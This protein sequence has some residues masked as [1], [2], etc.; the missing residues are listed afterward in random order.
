MTVQEQD[1]AWMENEKTAPNLRGN[2]CCFCYA[3]GQIW[4]MLSAVALMPLASLIPG[5]MRH[6]LIPI[7]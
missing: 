5:D 2:V 6:L 3:G 7:Y 4:I 1:R